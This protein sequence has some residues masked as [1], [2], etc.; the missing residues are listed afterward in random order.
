MLEK[1]NKARQSELLGRDMANDE[2]IAQ[3]V[4]ARAAGM[5]LRAIGQR[6]GLSPPRIGQILR[7][8]TH[9]VAC[10]EGHAA[11]AAL[12][13]AG[14]RA[15]V[16]AS[17]STALFFRRLSTNTRIQEVL[18]HDRLD[19]IGKIAATTPAELLR[20]PT[21]GRRLLATLIAVLADVGVTL[22]GP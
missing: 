1:L 14:D 12:A 2:R 11:V 3:I 15:A 7:N 4:A 10:L 9:E 20:C 22:Q 18:R 16:L 17:P 19:T 6:F 21:F 5:T 8:K 13:A